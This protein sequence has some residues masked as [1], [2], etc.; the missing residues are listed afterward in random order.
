MHRRVERRD[1]HIGTGMLNDPDRLEEL[2]MRK[3]QSELNARLPPKIKFGQVMAAQKPTAGKPKRNRP[4]SDAKLRPSGPSQQ[5]VGFGSEDDS[6]EIDDV[7][8]AK[9]AKV[10]VKV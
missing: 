3:Q 4:K 10:I 9:R 5:F 2:E 1:F 8:K 6:D 7:P